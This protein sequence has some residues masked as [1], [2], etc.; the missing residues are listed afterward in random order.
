MTNQEV[1]NHYVK[2]EHKQQMIAWNM[3]HLQLWLTVKFSASE[4]PSKRVYS[5]K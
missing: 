2:T 3:M 1:W 5:F 4:Q